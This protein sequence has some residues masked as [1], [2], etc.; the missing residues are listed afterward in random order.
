MCEYQIMLD[1]IT[2]LLS[3]RCCSAV[4]SNSDLY[5]DWRW[6]TQIHFWLPAV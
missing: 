5:R 6:K 2:F 3:F 4:P 1:L